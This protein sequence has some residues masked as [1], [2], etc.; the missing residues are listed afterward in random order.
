MGYVRSIIQ[1]AQQGCTTVAASRL[2]VFHTDASGVCDGV[3]AHFPDITGIPCREMIGR[4]WLQ[5]IFCDDRDRVCR[6]WYLSII[7]NMPFTSTFRIPGCAEQGLREV[8]CALVPELSDSGRTTGYLGVLVETGVSVRGI[9]HAANH[10]GEPSFASG[11]AEPVMHSGPAPRRAAMAM[12]QH[13]EAASR[14]YRKRMRR[15]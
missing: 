10:C 1:N 5:A 4:V 11:K 3:P 14:M 7:R 8:S 12:K 15:G 2:G 6:E 9:R 13:E